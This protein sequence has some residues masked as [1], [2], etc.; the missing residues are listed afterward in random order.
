MYQIYVWSG[1]AIFVIV[2]YLCVTRPV[3]EW[4]RLH[5]RRT[6]DLVQVGQGEALD[7]VDRFAYAITIKTA[8]SPF[9]TNSSAL[10]TLYTDSF[11]RV[12]VM[13]SRWMDIDYYYADPLWLETLERVWPVEQEPA[14]EE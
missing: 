8:P 6:N 13:K 11:G 2:G 3:F 4:V 9:T 1:I 5:L 14:Q 12:V 10:V 7:I